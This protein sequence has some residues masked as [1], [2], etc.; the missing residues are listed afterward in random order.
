MGGVIASLLNEVQP[1]DPLVLGVVLGI[2][3]T[4]GTV[5]AAAATLGGLQI[6]P[7][8]ALREE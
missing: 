6:D 3:A 7:A 1:H 4:V 8:A 2:V 5:A